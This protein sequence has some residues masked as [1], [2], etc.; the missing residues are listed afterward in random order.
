MVKYHLPLQVPATWHFVYLIAGV[1]KHLNDA[2]PLSNTP[3]GKR[4]VDGALSVRTP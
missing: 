4:K 2:P 1:F 3:S